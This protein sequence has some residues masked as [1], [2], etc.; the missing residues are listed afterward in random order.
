MLDRVGRVVS[1]T[2][3]K[4]S[5]DAALDG[6]ALAMMKRSDPVPQPPA[7]VADEGLTFTV[8]V[9]FRAKNAR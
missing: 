1:A 7:L 8:P 5:G 4:S 9:V 2:V 6:A 3:A